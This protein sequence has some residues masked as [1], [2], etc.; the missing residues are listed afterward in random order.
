M[1]KQ[2]T[3]D[4]PVKVALNF[5]ALAFNSVRKIAATNQFGALPFAIGT[6]L[7]QKSSKCLIQVRYGR[8]L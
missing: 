6:G 8:C 4:T 1:T 3:P 2:S 5:L 7:G